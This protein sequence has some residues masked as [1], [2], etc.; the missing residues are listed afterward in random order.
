MIRSDLNAY[1]GMNM[2]IR[3]HLCQL[4]IFFAGLVP[5]AHAATFCVD[6][7]ASLT[8]ALATAQSN[9]QDDNIYVAVGTYTLTEE[10]SYFAAPT[11][12]FTVNIIGGAP[13]VGCPGPPDLSSSTVLDGQNLV[14]QLSIIAKG[15]VS[16]GFISFVRGKPTVFAG[17]ALSIS[18]S[19]G[20][21]SVYVFDDVF[22]ANTA[23]NSGGAMFV[24]SPGTVY[25]WSNLMLANTGSPA[26]AIHLATTG[27]T[28][29]NGNS[30][31]GNQFVNQSGFGAVNIAGTGHYWLSNNIV[32]NNEGTD[33]YDQSGPTD[34][35]NNDIGVMDG[36]P[37]LSAVHEKNVDPGFV[38]IFGAMLGPD[39]PLVNAGLDNPPGFVGGC[40]D[41]THG[42]R[43]IGQHVDIGAYETDVL[44][45]NGYEPGS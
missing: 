12:F 1:Q 13:V 6:S 29:L 33:V 44:F 25:L 32:W 28:Y 31:V 2:R 39:S 14:R 40:C 16:V 9:N 24:A 23:A 22:I 17:G 7:I 21:S 20:S 42:P 27:N 19:V 43:L 30:I 11:E 35:A 18:N 10:L 41:P 5:A 37:P 34:Y 38:G 45:R 26:S 36:L 3:S 15:N 4:T 8:T